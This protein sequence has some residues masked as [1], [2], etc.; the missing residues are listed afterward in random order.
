LY[1]HDDPVNKVDPSGNLTLKEVLVVTFVVGVVLT[2][3]YILLAAYS[4]YKVP[5]LELE[6]QNLIS[7]DLK[8]IK[9]ASI[10]SLYYKSGKE[11]PKSSPAYDKIVKKIDDAKALASDEGDKRLNAALNKL[12]QYID[13]LEDHFV[14]DS[15]GLIFGM[16]GK[17]G[18]VDLGN[19]PSLID[20]A[21][22]EPEKMFNAKLYCNEK[23]LGRLIRG[24]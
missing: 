5:S 14:T 16:D 4:A 21:A 10:P 6:V 19:V 13:C 17:P 20:S 3:L 23:V 9:T 1:A 2:G 22:A 11:T 12:N 8:E 18:V 24:F 15:D 7:D